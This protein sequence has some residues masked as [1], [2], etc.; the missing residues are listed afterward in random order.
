MDNPRSEAAEEKTTILRECSE[1]E[2]EEA[3]T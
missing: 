1:Q 3:K 2:E